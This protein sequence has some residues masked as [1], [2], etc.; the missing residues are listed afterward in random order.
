MKT[1]IF[2]VT[3]MSCAACSATVENS[4][5]KIVGVKSASVSLATEEAKVVFSEE[6]T[7]EETI[8]STISK[9]GYKLSL[10][11]ETVNETSVEKLHKI[12]L[13]FC[14]SLSAILFVLCMF[15]VSGF[16]QLLLCIPVMIGGYT[17]FTKGFF[18]LFKGHPTMDSLVACGCS[19]SFI[20]STANLF[21][22]KNLFFFDGVAMIIAL[23]M[24]GKNIELSS[25]RKASESLKNLARLIP[26]KALVKEGD[27]FVEKDVSSIVVG[28][29]VRVRPGE[30]IPCDGSVVEGKAEVDESMLTGESLP[31]LKT[32]NSSVFGG[33]LNLNSSFDFVSTKTGKDTVLSSIID[34]V[35][36]AQNSKAPIQRITDKVASVFV[37]CVLGISFLVFGL[38]LGF[39]KDIARAIQNAVSV[40]VIACPCSLG[41]ATPIAVMVATAKGSSLGILFRNAEA[42]ENLGN[43]KS[44]MFDKTGTLTYGECEI[45]NTPSEETLYLAAIAEQKSEHPYARAILKANK[46]ELIDVRTFSAIPGEGVVVRCEEGKIHAGN[47][48]LMDNNDIVIPPS[49]DSTAQIFVAKD[50]EYVGCIVLKDK[51][52]EESKEVVSL[53]SNLNLNSI[54]LTGDN[55]QTAKAVAEEIGISNFKASLTPSEKYKFIED[56]EKC[57]MV[58]DGINDAPALEKADVGI[59]MG[60]ASDIAISSA[61]IIVVRNNLNAIPTA[62]RLSRETVKNIRLSLFWAFFYNCLGIPIAAGI[63]TLFGGPSLNPMISAACMSLSS[64]SVVLN[65]LRLRR[66]K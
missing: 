20:Y 33:T 1:V 35:K 58:G 3:G 5:N 50:G 32:E 16:I 62:I 41:L 9:T 46:K 63:L 60:S 30:R 40:L 47:K 56:S 55:N 43:M 37:P 14:I 57:I 12:R 38:W 17:F 36:E 7:N 21:T 53:L 15:K 27:S 10:L 23:V 13:C 42:L 31:V 11:T 44:V 66:F 49:E 22:G 2:K 6:E 39:T 59:A 51:L 26:S 61:D 34:M 28:A 64:I 65:A 29:I 19:A 52:R 18:S 24:V 4:L 48:D 25:K 45:A 8:I 54:M